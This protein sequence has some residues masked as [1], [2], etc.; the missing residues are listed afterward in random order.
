MKRNTDVLGLVGYPLGHS[1]SPLIHNTIYK[2]YGINCIYTLFETIPDKLRFRIEDIRSQDIKGVNVTIPFKE[3]I[4]E[5]I[6]ELDESSSGIGAVN[7]ILNENGV[8]KGYN[9][10]YYGFLKS[11]E[12]HKIDIRSRDIFVTGSGGAAKSVC[13]G[14]LKS[15]SKVYVFGRDAEKTQKL[16]SNYSQFNNDIFPCELSNIDENIA[17]IKPYM[18]VNC[19]PVGMKGYG[20]S[21]DIKSSSIK[22]NVEVLYDLV[23]NPSLTSFLALGKECGCRIVSGIDMLLLQAFA[24]IKIWTGKEIDIIIGKKILQQEGILT[25]M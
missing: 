13:Q 21:L 6:D 17:E 2:K 20:G 8:L 25:N 9:T 12:L 11:L 7:T 14:L 23:Y 18:I 4:I 19:T 3:K 5:Y 15:G 22:G 10:D 24:S 1:L 16:C